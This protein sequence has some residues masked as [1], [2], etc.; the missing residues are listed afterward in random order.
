[1]PG[2]VSRSPTTKRDG[3]RSPR[4][5]WPRT[6]GRRRSSATSCSIKGSRW[7]GSRH[8][9]AS[10]SAKRRP[11]PM[12]AG[13]APPCRKKERCISSRLPTG[14]IRPLASLQGQTVNKGAEI[15]TSS[16]FSQ[17]RDAD[18]FALK[19]KKSMYTK[20]LLE[21]Y[22]SRLEIEGQPQRGRVLCGP[23]RM[24]RTAI[25]SRSW[26]PTPTGRPGSGSNRGI[27]SGRCGPS[28]PLRTA[29]ICRFRKRDRRRTGLGAA[30]GGAAPPPGMRTALR[31]AAQP[32]PSEAEGPLLRVRE[33]V[34]RPF[35]PGRSRRA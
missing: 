8:I 24:T 23:G 13:F 22:Y 14:D 15:P 19:Y 17:P 35:I 1:M 21:V 31:Y 4:R 3:T 6:A 5:A 29:S 11:G 34:N 7:R 26:T 33:A 27:R 10:P 32:V 30:E 25:P 20:G 16:F 18:S 12:S 9:F 28:I 2:C